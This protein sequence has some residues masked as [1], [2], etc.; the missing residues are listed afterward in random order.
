VNVQSDE[1]SRKAA[2]LM[3]VELQ[4]GGRSVEES[5]N[6][7]ASRCDVAMPDVLSIER[8]G[9]DKSWPPLGDSA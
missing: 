9:L 8:E 2:F 4:D 3:L 5:R 1:T 7:V 6:E